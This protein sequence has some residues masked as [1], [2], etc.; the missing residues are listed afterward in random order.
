[1]DYL[2]DNDLYGILFKDIVN[3]YITVENNNLKEFASKVGV[4][5]TDII[6]DKIESTKITQYLNYEEI[7]P[8]ISKYLNIAIEAIPE[9]NYSKIEKGD[10]SLGDKTIQTD[11]YQMKL[12]V[13]DIQSI[14]A[15]VLESAK[16]DEQLF[17]LMSKFNKDITIEE[18]Q[19]SIN[20]ILTEFSGEISDE[21]NI[22]V[23]TISVYK[24]GK[25]TVKLLIE[26]GVE[27]P[28]NKI[29]LSVEKL[30]NSISLGY[31]YFNTTI[32]G[33][34]E[35]KI[36]IAKTSTSEEQETI[37][38]EISQIEDGEEQY[39]SKMT[40]SRSGAYTSNNISFGMSMSTAMPLLSEN[41]S[42]TISVNNTSDFSVAP[43]N[44]EFT[45]GNHLTIN[46]A[47]TEQLNNLFTNLGTKISEKLKDEMFVTIIRDIITVNDGLYQRAEQA[48][49]D[50]QNAIEEERALTE[51]MQGNFDQMP[52]INPTIDRG[53]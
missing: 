30:Q 31:D 51:Q 12:K 16:N 1:M 13:K 7:K 25:D 10:I 8:L 50:T 20:D 23:I 52:T 18:Y 17:N 48:V 47:S 9:D 4:Q 41:A 24:Q 3:Q 19:E 42:F 2:K 43:Q 32:A 49:Q 38:G 46:G 6:P 5:N 40:F 35:N 45:E 22:E 36:I 34:S 11:G 21:K 14:L 29:E 37:E 33:T 26:I 15:K 39:N 44:A 27:E 53:E 28:K